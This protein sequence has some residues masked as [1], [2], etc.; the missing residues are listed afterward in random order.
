MNSKT[1]VWLSALIAGIITWIFVYL[2]AKLFDNPKSKLVYFKSIVFVAGMVGL[3]VYFLTG[4]GSQGFQGLMRP[5]SF[6]NISSPQEMIQTGI[7]PF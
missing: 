5:G 7:A 4:A 2:D 3:V 6:G 1:S